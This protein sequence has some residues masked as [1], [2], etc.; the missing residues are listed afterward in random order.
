MPHGIDV[1]VGEDGLSTLLGVVANTYYS[2]DSHD[3]HDGF[4]MSITGFQ[5][6]FNG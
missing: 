3:V 6:R 5:N 1:N 2:L 4:Q